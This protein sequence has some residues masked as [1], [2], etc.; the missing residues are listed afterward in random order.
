MV[1]LQIQKFLDEQNL[2]VQELS[3]RTA[4]PIALLERYLSPVNIELEEQAFEDLQKISNVLEISPLCLIKPKGL[5][6]GFRLRLEE[7][8]QAKG[9]S[10]LDLCERTQISP[11]ILSFYTAHVFTT[12]SLKLQAQISTLDK[13]C[14]A[15]NCQIQDLLLEVE[16]SFVR[17]HIQD[18]LNSINLDFDSL[19]KLTNVPK[20]I[21]ELVE[22]NPIHPIFLSAVSERLL[23]KKTNS[24]ESTTTTVGTNTSSIFNIENSLSLKNTDQDWTFRTRE[25]IETTA[26]EFCCAVLKNPEC[27]KRVRRE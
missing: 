24:F 18:L 5:E 27:C 15:L 3:D 13:I 16:L 7:I 25:I 11:I 20:Q 26:D 4:I 22:I 9:I 8:A 21:L 12:A 19:E 17:F 10:F 6:K 14:E 23:I 2:S 1:T